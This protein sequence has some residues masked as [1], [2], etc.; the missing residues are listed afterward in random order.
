MVTLDMKSIRLCV[1]FQKVGQNRAIVNCDLHF[2]FYLTHFI[3]MALLFKPYHG[4]VSLIWLLYRKNR[5]IIIRI[6]STRFVR[7]FYV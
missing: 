5:Q 1:P 2:Y 7:V 4:S 6:Y 3:E